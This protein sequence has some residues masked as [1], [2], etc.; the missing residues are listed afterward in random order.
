MGVAHGSRP[1]TGVADLLLGCGVWY[2]LA[3]VL[4]IFIGA[5]F[6]LGWGG[7]FA[8][9]LMLIV[10]VP[11]HGATLVRVY[12]HRRDRKA[13]SLFTV[14][15]T[16]LIWSLFVA[17]VHSA[18]VGSIMLTV[19]L[20]WSPWHYTGQ[21]YGIAL[22]FLG[23]RGVTVSR[24]DKRLIYASFMLSYAL[25]FASMH[26]TGQ[27]RQFAWV[28][29]P[30]DGYRFLSLGLP[31]A[32]PL[33]SAIALAYLGVIVTIGAR[34][35]RRAPLRDLG[36]AAILVVSQAF[37][38]SLPVIVRTFHVQTGFDAWEA[39]PEYYFLWV[40]MAHA[41]QYLWVTRYYAKKSSDWNGSLPYFTKVFLAGAAIWT[42]P[43]VIFSPELF[44]RLPFSSGLGELVGA[45]VNLHHFVLDGAI[46][47]LRDQK[48]S[49]VLIRGNDEDVAEPI[50]P[51]RHRLRP[52]IWA[53][54]A[55][56]V[57]V[58]AMANYEQYFNV[59]LGFT[60]SRLD[61]VEA[62][63][64]RLAWL[65]RDN[66]EVRAALAG[67][68]ERVRDTDAAKRQ[69]LRALELRPTADGWREFG[70]FHV[71]N[72]SWSEAIDAFDEV[73]ASQPADM[74]ALS[75]QVDA[76]LA[77]G[78][79]A[80]ALQVVERAHAASLNDFASLALANKVAEATGSAPAKP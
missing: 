55:V 45:A 59:R 41:V 53:T 58:M 51:E 23:R 71:R 77:L 28:S 12:E 37:W 34:L 79:P 31:Y 49:R 19:F 72:E 40:G 11:H 18:T 38:F 63:L 35:L 62:A 54:G 44:G 48:I 13:Y 21:N 68:L 73:L 75:N 25:A 22:M 9:L 32:G 8:P 36:P 56:S 74:T 27:A 43:A 15:A 20:T 14:W 2:L 70:L 76:W 16:V 29:S 69:H 7:I 42:I 17:G 65:G 10:G 39:N 67:R 47:K 5:D 60:Y 26:T 1:A 30:G 52:W 4:F 57:A 50:Q 3:L 33:L 80:R 66:S 78:E 61:R 24:L 64:D 46:W 6:R